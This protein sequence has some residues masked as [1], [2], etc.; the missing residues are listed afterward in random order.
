MNTLATT[1]PALPPTIWQSEVLVD[2][3]NA[4]KPASVKKRELAPAADTGATQK[5]QF[6]DDKS[7]QAQMHNALLAGSAP[8]LAPPIAP[9]GIDAT[10]KL[11]TNVIALNY[12]SLDVNLDLFQEKLRDFFEEK[13]E[14]M[15]PKFISGLLATAADAGKK[16][17]NKLEDLKDINDRYNKEHKE[18]RDKLGKVVD[19]YLAGSTKAT[20]ATLFSA[21][22]TALI[23]LKSLTVESKAEVV[24]L[25]MALA[26]ASAEYQAEQIVEQG[27]MTMVGGAVNAAMTVSMAGTG[28]LVQRGSFKP[29]NDAFKL[30]LEIRDNKLELNSLLQ[31]KPNLEME[32]NQRVTSLQ[33]ETQAANRTHYQREINSL[34][35]DINE[36][37]RLIKHYEGKK[38]DRITGVD[39]IETD[40]VAQF[41]DQKFLRESRPILAE[42]E[43]RKKSL[44][45]EYENNYG[46][47]LSEHQ[48]GID[49]R[50]EELSR[51]EDR[52]KFLEGEIQ[53]AE[54]DTYYLDI[55][56]N[57]QSMLGFAIV[58]MTGIASL[59][60]SI[61]G[62]FAQT[63]QAAATID[64]TDASNYQ[65][66][67]QLGLQEL[68][69]LMSA[70]DALIS[71]LTEVWRSQNEARGV[72]VSNT[73]MQA[74]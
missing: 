56:A 45:A 58:N 74:I 3:I 43:S 34:S 68:Q 28:Y 63:A 23:S 51:L 48:S 26:Y 62:S 65:Q 52:V 60:Q 4:T 19:D 37:A 14:E 16:F 47:T 71:L 64:Q 31:Q 33:M 66:V 54:H 29:K 8:K 25:F 72:M 53:K 67:V 50:R 44:I 46:R 27:F 41:N 6:V 7:N 20:Y 17:L 2:D 12:L 35:K 13:L 11:L 55:D 70:L 1:M 24:G 22:I 5:T 61:M 57:Q 38:Y 30:G 9:T 18:L 59:G 40:V 15:D 32:I 10:F 36:R 69:S 73:K 42:L 21:V 49:T 39:T